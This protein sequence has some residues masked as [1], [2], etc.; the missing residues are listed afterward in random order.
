MTPYYQDEH[1]TLWHGD[2]RELTQ[3]LKADVLV[4][5]PP[6][7]TQVLNGLGVNH[8]GYGRRQNAAGNSRHASTRTNVNREGFTI[9][10]DM[11]TEVRDAAL[12]AW[13]NR[14]ALL[15]GS[16][17]MPDP[18]MAV[19]DRLVWN[20]KRP[21]MNAG[22]WRYT[23]EAIYVTAGFVRTSDAAVSILTAFPEQADHI[24]G[25]PLGLMVELVAAA[26]PGVIADPF[27]GSGSTLVAAKRLGRQA[28][29]VELE[30]RYCE[31]IAKR[32][33]QG[34]LDFRIGA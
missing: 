29:G 27:A 13:G 7:G 11:T 19:A 34:V 31:I 17:R 30:E 4:T 5:D 8:G 1:I 25:K 3:W 26:P 32:L 18:P 23:H 28:I 33:D 24:H 20:K 16:P 9:A 6:Y 10:N 21:G 2:C 12:E 22:P 15:F 14:P